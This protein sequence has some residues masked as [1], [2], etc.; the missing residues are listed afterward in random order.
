MTTPRTG[1]PVLDAVLDQPGA[2]LAIAHRGGARHPDLLGLENTMAAFAHAVALGY[3]FLETDVHA[4][5][6]GVLLAF[7]DDRLDRVTTATGLLARLDH[8][9]VTDALVAGR[10]PVPTMAD[11]LAALPDVRF[12]IDLKSVPAIVPFARLLAETG[13]EDRVCVGAFSSRRLRAFRKASGGRVA[14]SAGPWLVAAARFLPARAAITVLRRH[15]A[16]ALQVPHRLKG[17]W[18]VVTTPELVRR[19]HA[20]GKHVHVWT[21]DDRDEIHELC[22]RGVDGIMT[23]RTDVLREVL[24]ARGQWREQRSTP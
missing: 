15:P 7:H 1:F 10:E 12:N 21:I 3:D 20:A 24:Q 13:N 5:A 22:D 23:D 18:P 14:T 8:A 19:A 9:A 11:L 2:V 4:T 16:A 6:D 17:R